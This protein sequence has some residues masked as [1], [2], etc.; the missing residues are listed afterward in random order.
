M[1]TECHVTCMLLLSGGTDQ[2][3][4]EDI[5]TNTKVWDSPEEVQELMLGSHMKVQV[6]EHALA[7]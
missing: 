2:H 5:S 7:S 3:A 1:T 4:V 6:R